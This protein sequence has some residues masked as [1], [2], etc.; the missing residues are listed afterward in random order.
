MTRAR[1]SSSPDGRSEPYIGLRWVL[2]REPAFTRYGGERR[3]TTGGKLR[4]LLI[5]D[6]NLSLSPRSPSALPSWRRG[7]LSGKVSGLVVDEAGGIEHGYVIIGLDSTSLDTVLLCIVACSTKYFAS[8]IF[9][10]LILSLSLQLND[11]WER[12]R[13][14]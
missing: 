11:P 3:G 6:S 7:S 5:P 1:P 4:I 8:T 14:A 10:P 13:Q 2:F 12:K 9:H